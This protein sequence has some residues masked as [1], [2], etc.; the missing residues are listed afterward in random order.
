MATKVTMKKVISLGTN[1][2]VQFIAKEGQGI[3]TGQ[4]LII[5]ESEF[6]DDSISKALD[7]LG[8]EFEEEIQELTNKIVKSK[9]T[10]QIVKVN[11]YYNKDLTEFSP[12][13]QKILKPYITKNKKRAT[14]VN[15]LKDNLEQDIPLDMSIDNIEKT[16]L[17]K[18]N[19]ND[20]DGLLLEFY[21]EY[22]D[23]LSIGDKVSFSTALKT[24]V[25]DVIE[26]GEEPYSEYKP[27]EEIEAILSPLSVVSRMT[28]DLFCILFLNKALLGL[29]DNISKML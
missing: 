18:I 14:I 2:N 29:K 19:G 26:S 23:E 1:S 15:G 27:D 5:F 12:S 21:I 8:S 11:M 28:G 10:G 7:K 3:K 22:E 25:S 4:P 20:I 17:D 16:S 24:V 9:Y 13:I 6:D